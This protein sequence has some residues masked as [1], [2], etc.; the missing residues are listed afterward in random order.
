[1]KDPLLSPSRRAINN[2]AIF[3]V[4]PSRKTLNKFDYP[5][6]IGLLFIQKRL[7]SYFHKI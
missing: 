3:Y 7:K 5:A 2:Y 1:M 4:K 6:F